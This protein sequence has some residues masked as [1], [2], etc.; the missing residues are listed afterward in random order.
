MKPILAINWKVAVAELLVGTLTATAADPT[1]WPWAN[2]PPMGWNSWDCYG[3]GVWESNVVANADY[4][5]QFLKPHGWDIVTIDIQWYEPLAHG[6]GY[7]RGAVLEMDANGRLLPATNRFPMTAATQSFKPMGDYLHAKGLKF[8]LHLMRGIPRQAVD[9]DNSPILGT[10]L[11]SRGHR[12]QELHLR[13]EHRHVWS[14]HD[15]ARRAGVLRFRVRPDGILGSG[16][17]ESGRSFVAIPQ[18]R[19]RSHPQGD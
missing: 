16:L 8:G 11:P 10:S 19:N 14:G 4:M 1:F 18:G 12:Q 5:A 15:Q 3:A 6:T 9:R 13:L 2:T 7:R 17:C